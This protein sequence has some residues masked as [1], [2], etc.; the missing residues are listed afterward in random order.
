MLEEYDNLHLERVTYLINLF[1]KF[2]DQ[3]IQVLSKCK[4]TENITFLAN[5]LQGF[6]LVEME[7]RETRYLREQVE[8]LEKQIA[9]KLEGIKDEK[10]Y[11]NVK[12][13]I[14]RPMEMNLQKEKEYSVEQESRNEIIVEPKEIRLSGSGVVEY[15]EKH[16][17]SGESPDKGKIKISM[18]SIDQLGDFS[19][20]NLE[21]NLNSMRHQATVRKDSER[22]LDQ[23]I[24][25]V[26]ID[27][28]P[29]TSRS[30]RSSPK[31]QKENPSGMPLK[32]NKRRTTFKKKK[33]KEIEIEEIDEILKG[34]QKEEEES[35]K[36][37]EES[38][39]KVK[40]VKK[41]KTDKKKDKKKGGRSKSV[42]SVVKKKKK[43]KFKTEN[44]SVSPF[45]TGELKHEIEDDDVDTMNNVV[46][47]KS[48]S[49]NRKRKKTR[50][51]SKNKSKLTRK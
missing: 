35:E 33:K 19:K 13:Q 36:R 22:H 38:E 41:S 27:T 17:N 34:Q 7:K 43:G 26:K 18:D 23:A 46:N 28:D 4:P 20:R 48:K 25:E 3:I 1:K 29:Y 14:Y 44:K 31:K 51:K 50:N 16:V 47:V 11:T 32:L 2:C 49:T 30:G 40:I 8:Y 15:L 9:Y 39:K 21:F 37:E 42:K 24:D 45:Q 12:D 5:L 6:I 10:L